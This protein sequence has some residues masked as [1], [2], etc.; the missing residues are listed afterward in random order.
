MCI[1]FLKHLNLGGLSSFQDVDDGA[2]VSGWWH[3]NRKQVEL[4]E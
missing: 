2:K 4:I 3:I 1:A